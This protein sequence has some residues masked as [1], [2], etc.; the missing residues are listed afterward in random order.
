MQWN[1]TCENG[2]CNGRKHTKDLNTP[3]IVLLYL[4]YTMKGEARDR[5]TPDAVPTNCLKTPYPATG[6]VFAFFLENIEV[7][8][9]YLIP[10]QWSTLPMVV[11]W[12]VHCWDG[13]WDS[14]MSK[15]NLYFL[16]SSPLTMLRTPSFQ[17]FS[18]PYYVSKDI[19]EFIH[20]FNQDMGWEC[21]EIWAE[22]GVETRGSNGGC[23]N[24]RCGKEALNWVK[25]RAEFFAVLALLLGWKQTQSID[26]FLC[27]KAPLNMARYSK[28]QHLNQPWMLQGKCRN[29][30]LYRFKMVF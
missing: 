19:L 28:R 8:R 2:L 29:Q 4:N 27:F 22:V 3:V 23:M 24:L 15:C 13:S 30:S 14:L 1:K 9:W 20:V 10:M 7:Q 16:L 5:S 11:H 6:V 17:C 26:R 12:M 18:H 21:N 25:S